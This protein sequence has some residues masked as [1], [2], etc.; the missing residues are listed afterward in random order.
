MGRPR[1]S[2]TVVGKQFDAAE[3]PIYMLDSRRRIAYCNP[4]CGQWLGVEN[5]EDLVG[6]RCDYHSLTD[7]STNQIDEQAASLCPPLEVFDG[8]ELVAKVDNGTRA[9]WMRFLPIRD[10][11]A[12]G[13]GVLAIPVGTPSDLPKPDQAEYLHDQI[14]VV[15]KK[16]QTDNSVNRIVGQSDAMQLVRRQV[17]AASASRSN[18]AI[19]GPAGSGR[20]AV[21]RAIH[22]AA[23]DS[24][25]RALMPLSCELLDSELLDSMLNAF[26]NRTSELQDSASTLLLLNI[27][28]LDPGSHQTLAEFLAAHDHLQAIATSKRP[29]VGDARQCRNDRRAPSL[30]SL[31]AMMTIVVPPLQDRLA[32]I[33]VLVQSAIERCNAIGEKQIGRIAPDALDRLAAHRWL[34]EVEE[35]FQIVAQAHENASG[36]TIQLSDLPEILEVARDAEQHPRHEPV[37]IDLDAFLAEAETELILR[38]LQESKGNKTQ[39]ASLLGI[40]RARL[41]RR[42]EQLK[43]EL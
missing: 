21:A 1:S 24:D 35:L 43:I 41:L 20:E 33:P 29:L 12:G 32:D 42:I 23:A 10:A 40:N 6:R 14:R 3:N 25:K 30:G 38:A 17:V 13:Y 22:Y 36:T 18:V 31:L 15:R 37:Q 7:D 39:A 5:E 16:L 4:A 8:R 9:Y 2:K 27:D 28:S 11:E 34:G 26:T 19:I